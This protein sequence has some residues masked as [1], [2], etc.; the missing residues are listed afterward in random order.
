[1]GAPLRE[2]GMILES[3]LQ[4]RSEGS[5][6]RAAASPLRR[7]H[8]GRGHSRQTYV[9]MAA[10]GRRQGRMGKNATREVTAMALAG[11]TCPSEIRRK[12]MSRKE[13]SLSTSPEKLERDRVEWSSQRKSLRE[14]MVL[15]TLSS[16]FISYRGVRGQREDTH[17]RILWNG[18]KGSC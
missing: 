5:F 6:G 3:E 7:G 9:L 13:W 8:R 11:G 4:S 18:K 2:W 17:H 15:S 1:M 14:W 12:K 10:E 16:V